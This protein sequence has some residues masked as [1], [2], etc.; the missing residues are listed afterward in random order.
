MPATLAQVV[1]GIM[2]VP[3]V[4]GVAP[5]SPLQ[6]FS[7]S[8]VQPVGRIKASRPTWPSAPILPAR[9]PPPRTGMVPQKRSFAAK[10][11]ARRIAAQQGEWQAPSSTTH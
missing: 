2:P 10:V 9:P 7:G 8:L 6:T 3:A 5:T 4:V 11:V 1:A